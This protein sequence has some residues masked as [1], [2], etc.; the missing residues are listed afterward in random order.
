MKPF[1]FHLSVLMAAGMFAGSVTALAQEKSQP[2]GMSP[3]QAI[4][5]TSRLVTL[6]VV[7]VDQYGKFVDGID[8]SKFHITDA[9]V[10]Q[11]IR[12]FEAPSVHLMPASSQAIVHS[13]EDLPKIGA[14]PVNV[15]VIDELNTPF[16]QTAYAQQ[17]LTKYLKQQPEVLAQPTLFIAVGS[18]RIAVLHDFTQDRDALIESVK[19]HVT[20]P[21]FE[22]MISSLNGGRRG[23]NHGL[24][25]TLGP[26]LQLA[27]AMR[28]IPGRKNVIWVGTGYRRA[29]GGS[30][31][32]G[33]EVSATR[34]VRMVTNQMLGAHI[35]FYTIDPEGPAVHGN[36]PFPAGSPGDTDTDSLANLP[37]TSFDS[38][39][40]STG[41]EILFGRN[42]INAEVKETTLEGSHYYTMAY[43]P[44]GQNL[45]ETDHPYHAIRVTVDVPNVRVITRDGY[46]GGT[47]LVPRVKA[48]TEK[49]QPK[50]IRFDLLGAASNSMVYTGLHTEAATTKDGF[51]LLVRGKDLHW[52]P[53]ADGS[54]HSEVTVVAVCYGDKDKVL[55][56]KAAQ[57]TEVLDPKEK[58]GDDN[59]VG[60]AFPM[61]VPAGTRHVRFVL[62]DADAGTMG[63]A[64]FAVPPAVASAK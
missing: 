44:A 5:V 35:T 46:F 6:D 36:D 42:D 57:L 40:R 23:V 21:D 29:N 7:V 60:F 4:Q 52:S 31:S 38:F 9:R 28:G 26:M 12:N 1:A 62:R 48:N 33:D 15:L 51:A 22:F 63:T 56:Q 3:D 24:G 10:P 50:M 19:T 49:K 14:A 47:E 32:Q 41:G 30:Y 25:R 55:Q 53:E 43:V 61:D 2:N 34:A 54:Q 11:N 58:L 27:A 59:R 17:M 20:A 64:N 45:A 8:R 18:E 37:G 16:V 13:T 39:A